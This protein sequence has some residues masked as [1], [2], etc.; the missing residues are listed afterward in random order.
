MDDSGIVL[1]VVFTWRGER[2]RIISA[3][4]AEKQEREFYKGEA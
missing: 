3:R 2:I 1:V 4:K